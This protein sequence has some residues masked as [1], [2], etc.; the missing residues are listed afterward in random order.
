MDVVRCFLLLNVLV[1]TASTALHA[2]TLSAD[3]ARVLTISDTVV[4]TA[5]RTPEHLKEVPLAISRVTSEMFSASRGYEVKDAI[6]LVPGV[7]TQSR[8]GHSDL[9]ITI[10]GFGTRGAGDRS[11]AGN[12]RGIRVLVDGIPETEPDGRTSLD[13][14]DLAAYESVDVMRSNASALYG[15]AAG[16]VVSFR[17]NTSF[18]KSFVDVG[19]RVGA[20]DFRKESLSAGAVTSN[21]HLL[22]TASDAAY[23]GYRKHSE[24]STGNVNMLVD[25]TLGAQTSLQIVAGGA[26]NMMR[27]PGPLTF[28][29]FEADP[30]QADAAYVQHDDHRFNRVGRFG[31]TLDHSAGEH[32]IAGTVFFQPK[33]LTRSERNSWREFNRYSLG[34]EAR[35]IWTTSFSDRAHST[36]LAGFDQQFQDGTIQFFSLTPS[37]ARGAITQDKREASSNEGFYVQ[38]EFKLGDLVLIAG[39]RYDRIGY[40]YEDVLGKNQ[41]DQIQFRSFAPKI[42]AGYLLNENQTIYA[43]YGG[44]MEAPAFNE[45]DP[46]DSATT[47]ERGGLWDPNAAFNPFLEPATS[48]TVEAGWKGVTSV[49]E[50][51]PAVSFDVAAFY[52]RVGNDIIPWNGGA[53]YFTAG[54]THRAGAEMALAAFTNVGLSLRTAWTY[55]NA[56]YDDYRSNLGDFSGNKQAGVPN[57]FG[58][59]RLR[60]THPLGIYFEGGLEHVGE[61][62][63]DDRN[64]ELPDGQP[65]PAI[66]SLV[67]AYSALNASAG[68]S[69]KVTDALHV[70]AFIALNNLTDARY[71]GSVFVNGTNNRYFEPGMPRNIAA[72]LNLRHEL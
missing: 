32:R 5:T 26:S 35:Y 40:G 23:T 52:I 64:D 72:G 31:L 30:T 39:G 27:F 11:N 37:V 25:A 49:S 71:V 36:F 69:A 33:V 66:R 2:Q 62:F 70:S 24:S 45:V 57:L 34:S 48:S 61:Y 50:F 47:V 14:V 10:R 44:G 16:G 29:Q 41:S 13:N 9:R 51:L 58:G 19:G 3:S 18:P 65:D 43:S 7:F 6:A 8:S 17:S 67:P 42:A 4:V 46:P 22:L 53:Y 1:V 55:M 59:A 56:V 21:T 68:Y 63:A 54:E 20:F 38:E 60:Y 15:S 12:M 28:L